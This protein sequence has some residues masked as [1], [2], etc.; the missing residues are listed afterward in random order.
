VSFLDWFSLIIL[1]AVIVGLSRSRN[2]G[3]VINRPNPTT[4]APPPRKLNPPSGGNNVK[5]NNK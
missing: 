3:Y 5:Y 1:I 4:D 2:Q